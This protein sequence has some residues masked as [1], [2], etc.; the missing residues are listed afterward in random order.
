MVELNNIRYPSAEQRYYNNNHTSPISEAQTIT[1]LEYYTTIL[2]IENYNLFA[3]L[4]DYLYHRNDMTTDQIKSR[5]D[6]ITDI[7][8][9]IKLLNE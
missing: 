1:Y 2:E 9:K 3:A 5:K 8:N 7:K 6:I 4:K